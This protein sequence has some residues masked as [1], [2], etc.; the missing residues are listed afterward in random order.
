MVGTVNTDKIFVW[1]NNYEK[2]LEPGGS[3]TLLTSKQRQELAG[4]S[5]NEQQSLGSR[6]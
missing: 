1:L 5:Y 3:V 2:D 6:P 4:H